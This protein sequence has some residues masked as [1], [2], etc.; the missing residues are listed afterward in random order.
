MGP[1]RVEYLSDIL[2]RHNRLSQAIVQQDSCHGTNYTSIPLHSL[3]YSQPQT[4]PKWI[5]ICKIIYI[6]ILTIIQLQICQ[7][8]CNFVDKRSHSR[9]TDKYIL[10]QDYLDCTCPVHYSS[11]WFHIITFEGI[12]SPQSS[13]TPRPP[14]PHDLHSAIIKSQAFWPQGSTVDKIRPTSF[15]SFYQAWMIIFFLLKRSVGSPSIPN[16]CDQMLS[17]RVIRT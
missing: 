8:G 10:T 11:I 13:T 1:Q 6:F 12:I 5:A 4:E 7:N 16:W 9:Y 14:P 17:G 3:G 2:C 15:A